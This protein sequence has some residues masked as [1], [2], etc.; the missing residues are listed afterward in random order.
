MKVRFR[1]RWCF[2]ERLEQC[3]LATIN[4]EARLRTASGRIADEKRTLHNHGCRV[5]DIINI[6]PDAIGCVRTIRRK[7][8][9]PGCW[10]FTPGTRLL[11]ASRRWG[12]VTS[13]SS[14]CDEIAK[15]RCPYVS[16]HGE[17]IRP[18][19]PIGLAD[20]PDG[21]QRSLEMHRGWLPIRPTF[22]GV[23]DI[24]CT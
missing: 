3:A 8:P 10:E 16:G 6:R 12:R 7:S 1:Q 9:K 22:N 21:S 17:T 23:S 20:G 14:I 4:S 2:Y 5:A 11:C 24:S 18:D 15:V 19:D 13:L